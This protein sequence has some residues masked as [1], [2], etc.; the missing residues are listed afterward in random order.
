MR[1]LGVLG[2]FMVRRAGR[3][4]LDG[5]LDGLEAIVRADAPA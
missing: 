2:G 4:Q 1:G 5:A 3:R